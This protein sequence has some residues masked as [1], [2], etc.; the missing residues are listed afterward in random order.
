MTINE[1]APENFT[2]PSL[3]PKLRSLSDQV[4]TGRGVIAF[5]GLDPASYSTFENAA[6]FAGIASYIAEQRGFQNIYN[7]HLS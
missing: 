7:D 3:G 2:L 5:R 6:I 4:Y 1:I